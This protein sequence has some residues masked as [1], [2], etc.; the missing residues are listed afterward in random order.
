MDEMHGSV[1][2]IRYVGIHRNSIFVGNTCQ[3]S[4]TPVVI[5]HCSGTQLCLCV[6]EGGG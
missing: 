5:P 4:T 1:N 3:I 2:C 6:G